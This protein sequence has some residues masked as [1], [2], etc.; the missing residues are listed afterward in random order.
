VGLVKGIFQNVRI[1]GNTTQT[2]KY[3]IG[4]NLGLGTY[5]LFA[6]AI[7]V[8]KLRAGLRPVGVGRRKLRRIGIKGKGLRLDCVK[9]NKNAMKT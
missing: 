1:T 9:R 8:R 5:A 3:V 2:L 7:G 4:N 6:L